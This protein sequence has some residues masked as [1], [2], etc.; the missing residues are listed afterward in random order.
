MH[1]KPKPLRRGLAC[2][3][4]FFSEWGLRFPAIGQQCGHSIE[5]TEVGSGPTRSVRE[6]VD[7]AMSGLK[8]RPAWGKPN[9]RLTLV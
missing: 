4:V 9:S 8:R 5:W 3:R 6:L 1:A 2:Q 7:P